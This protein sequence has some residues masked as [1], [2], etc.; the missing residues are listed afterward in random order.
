MKKIFFTALLFVSLLSNAFASD[1]GK[2]DIK[3]VNNFRSSF[4]H[5]NNVS[6]TLKATFVQADF[7]INGKKLSAYYQFN[8]ELIG[9]SEKISLDELPVNA[10][11]KFAKKYSGFTVKEAIKFESADEVA[12]FISAENENRSEIVK[13]SD[14]GSVSVFKKL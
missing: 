7:E 10:K 11:R 1:E 4:R 12:Y 3:V 5:A 2:V 8:G 13:V 9:T 6:W 14:T